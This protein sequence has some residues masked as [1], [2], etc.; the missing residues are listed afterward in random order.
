MENDINKTISCSNCGLQI[1]ENYCR[2]CGQFYN[3]KRL[4]ARGFISD[5]ADS[6]FSLK[7]SYLLNLKQ[8]LLKPRIVVKNYWNGYRNFFFSPNRMLI[9]T[10][11]LISIYLYFTKDRF[12]GVEFQLGNEYSWLGIQ[13]LVVVFLLFFFVLATMITYYKKK[14]NFFEHIA[15]NS[16][17]FSVITPIFLFLAIVLSYFAEQNILQPLFSI[18][19]F[20]WI[21][22]VFESKWQKILIM[23]TLNLII[24]LALIVPFFYGMIILSTQLKT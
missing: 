4:D 18:F 7:R 15:L 16:Y 2:N 14:K 5:F 12:F 11:F 9:I 3:S 23:A 8:L 20:V 13:F 22:R 24:F 10:A 17:I 6:F 19:Y 21:A 1:E